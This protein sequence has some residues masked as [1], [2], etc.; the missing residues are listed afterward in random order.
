MSSY[1]LLNK[2]Q[3]TIEANRSAAESALI[4]GKIHAIGFIKT[5]GTVPLSDK[6]MSYA[7]YDE[8]S[9]FIFMSDHYGEMK[10]WEADW[11]EEA[12]ESDSK[13]ASNGQLIL[14]ASDPLDG[15]IRGTLLSDDL[16]YDFYKDHWIKVATSLED[17]VKLAKTNP[18][19]WTILPSKGETVIL[20]CRP[21]GAVADE[22]DF[23][24]DLRPDW[25]YL[26]SRVTS[27]GGVNVYKFAWKKDPESGIWYIS[28]KQTHIVIKYPNGKVFV[29]EMTIDVEEAKFNQPF[30]EK[31]YTFAGLGL[32]PDSRVSDMRSEPPQEYVYE[33]TDVLANNVIKGSEP[34]GIANWKNHLQLEFSYILL[35]INATGIAIFCGFF[36]SRRKT[37]THT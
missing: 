19:L 5:K 24:I 9:D 26:P 34:V 22:F 2:M 12:I 6:V 37:G 31:N 29:Q 1:E 27:I 11:G 30:N 7:P 20:K 17:V 32:K 36:Y 18:E 21:E 33:Q 14:D 35:L 4:K 25:N 23:Y 8:K 10:R 13:F 3:I 16:Y 28:K 15:Y